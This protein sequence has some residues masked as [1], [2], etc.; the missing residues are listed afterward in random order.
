MEGNESDRET[1]DQS[2]SVRSLIEVTCGTKD[3]STITCI[4]LV[5][6]VTIPAIIQEE[7]VHLQKLSL[8]NG[9][10]SKIENLERLTSLREL[11][12]SNNKIRRLKGLEYNINLEV[13]RLDG[14]PIRMLKESVITRLENLKELSLCN[15]CIH[16]LCQTA[17]TLFS[18]KELRVLKFQRSKLRHPID[19]GDKSEESEAKSNSPLR[20]ATALLELINKSMNFNIN[21]RLSQLLQYHT[22]RTEE[23]PPIFP[24]EP[25]DTNPESY[26]SDEDSEGEGSSSDD[27]DEE[28]WQIQMKMDSDRSEEQTLDDYL[29]DFHQVSPLCSEP[30]YRAYLIRSIPQLIFLDEREINQN[31]KALASTIYN[32]HFETVP[33]DFP[34]VVNLTNLLKSR[35]YKFACKGAPSLHLEESMAASFYVRHRRPRFEKLGISAEFIPRQFE[36]NPNRPD[37]LVYGTTN[38]ELVVI[39]P[40]SN[41]EVGRTHARSSAHVLGLCWLHGTQGETKFV[42]GSDNGEVRLIDTKLIQESKNPVVFNFENF[43]R[44]SSVTVNCNDDFLLTSGHTHDIRLYDLH[45]GKTVQ[46]YHGIH[47]GYINVLKFANHDPNL[48]ATS[49]FD[50]SVKMWDVREKLSK[51]IY[52]RRSRRGIVMVAWSPNDKYIL[53]SAADNEV[54]QYIASDGTLDRSFDIKRTDNDHNY[55]RSYYMGNDY[56]IVGSCEES[57]VRIYSVNSGKLF[58]DVEF[59]K[60][61]SGYLKYIQSLRSDPFHPFSFT[62]LIAFRPPYL[63]FDL[64]KVDL[65]ERKEYL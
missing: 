24:N 34:K 27:I 3:L 25:N 56:I 55:T 15:S 23:T 31:E 50:H 7:L 41:K 38:G 54:R 47:S 33:Y 10:I 22:N 6:L 5:Q 64:V 26:E 48:F 46:N 49:S 30:H 18:L 19:I 43:Y 1:D 59:D 20:H 42:A 13:L 8:T 9:W 14:N 65:F 40:H 44:L 37:R 36:Y 57:L 45:T 4:S 39:N 35:E 63:P 51:P 53:T 28:S 61:S 21:E 58:R 32:S 16:N 62:A 11:N 29:Y 52:S 17:D 12:L 2:T 60:T